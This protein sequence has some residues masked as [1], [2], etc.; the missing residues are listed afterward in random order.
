MARLSPQ[1]VKPRLTSGGE[2]A[3]LDVREHG[4]YGDGHPFFAVPAPYSRLETDIPGLVPRT[5]TPVVLL[6]DGDGIAE[7]AARPAG[8]RRA[9][10]CTR[11]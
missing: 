8:R 7:R 6:D 11:V 4:Q 1:A 9:T 2:V 10:R 5:S 3:F